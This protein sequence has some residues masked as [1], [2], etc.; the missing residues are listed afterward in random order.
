[1]PDFLDTLAEDAKATVASGYHEPPRKANIIHASL[2]TAIAQSRNAVIIEVKAASP[3]AGTI[4]K[5]FDAGKI[6]QAMAQGGAVGISVLTE[7][8]HFN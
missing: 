8:K 3:S 7:P 6:A 4:R 1:M 5:D 2:K